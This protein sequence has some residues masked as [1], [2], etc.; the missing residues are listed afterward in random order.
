MH[1]NALTFLAAGNVTLLTS[2]VIPECRGGAASPGTVGPFGPPGTGSKKTLKIYSYFNS[3]QHV[4][5]FAY[6][7]L[8]KKCCA[9]RCSCVVLSS[10]MLYFVKHV[11]AN[12]VKF[13]CIT[14]SCMLQV[15][16]GLQKNCSA[17]LPFDTTLSRWAV[18]NQNFS[19]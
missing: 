2:N 1:G 19:S 6:S 8:T 4:A 16:M 7:R 17:I 14:Q 5:R 18:S 15:R 10:T 12:L 9:T 13:S 3:M 11:A